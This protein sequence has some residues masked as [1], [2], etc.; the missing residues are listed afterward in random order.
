MSRRVEVTSEREVITYAEFWHTSFCLLE[1]TKEIEE[2]SYHLIMGSLV[3][4]AFAFEAFLNHTGKK[5]YF[6][7]DDLEKLNPKEKLN[8]ISEKIEL[9]VD[10]GIRPWQSMTEL[11]Q[12]RNDIAHGKTHNI[13]ISK[14][15]S[16]DKHNKNSSPLKYRAES[17]WEK[18]CTRTNAEKARQDV[19]AMVNAIYSAAK[20][21]GYPFQMG[22]EIGGSTVLPDE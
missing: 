14:I 21:E 4:T 13:S 6:C 8:V 10:Y 9:E 5:V 7:W 3:F 16:L 2:G 1:M 18:Y 15:E 22:F 19:V 12:F 20:M 11:F 17:R